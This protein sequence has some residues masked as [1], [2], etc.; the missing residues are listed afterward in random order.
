MAAFVYTAR[1]TQGQRVRGRVDATS[2]QEALESLRAAGLIITGLAPD[3]SID[4]V[5]IWQGLG[6]R[7]SQRPDLAALG[8]FCRQMAILLEAGVPI[9]HALQTAAR[10]P[11]VAPLKGAIETAAQRL[12]GGGSLRESFASQDSPFPALMEQMLAASE[13]GGFLDEAFRRLADHFEREEGLRQRVRNATVY[14]KI[15]GVAALGLLALLVLFVA[16]NFADLFDQMGVKMPAPTR[17]LL[18]IA[19]TGRTYWTALALAILLAYVGW[20]AFLGTPRGRRLGER[21]MTRVPLFGELAQKQALS[22]FARTFGTLMAGGVPVLQALRS[23]RQLAGSL[24]FEEALDQA[25]EEVR[26][27][28]NLHEPLARSGVL[29]PLAA[30]MLATGEEAGAI[31]QSLLRIADIYEQECDRLAGRIGAVLEPAIMLVLGLLVAFIL[32]SIFIPMFDVYQH[33]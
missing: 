30:T 4:L 7:S 18:A 22:R 13:L 32:G 26:Q 23:V 2:M 17:M 1:N 31:T 3:N 20:R 28:G 33:L 9:L 27:G 10:Q 16:P 19:A 12:E 21:W 24:R 15:V 11:G 25:A 5:G 6:V 14:P 8:L 29:P